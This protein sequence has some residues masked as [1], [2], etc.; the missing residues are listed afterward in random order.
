[1]KSLLDSSSS[2]TL[3]DVNSEVGDGKSPERV[4]STRES[5]SGSVNQNSVHVSNVNNNNNFA[6]VFSKVHEGNSSW[7]DKLFVDLKSRSS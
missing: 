7:L 5:S 4:E 1:M 3:E 2:G 6:V